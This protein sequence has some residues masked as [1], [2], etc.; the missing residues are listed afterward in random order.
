MLLYTFLNHDKYWKN[1]VFGIEIMFAF[2][3]FSFNIYC[4]PMEQWWFRCKLNFFRFLLHTWRNIS[5]RWNETFEDSFLTT[6]V[7]FFK[8]FS[9]TSFDKYFRILFR[10][11][12]WF[13][14]D[15]MIIYAILVFF[16]EYIDRR[17]F[18]AIWSRF[19]G[20]PRNPFT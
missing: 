11:C 9:L 19:L 2:F 18:D 7:E 6:L 14:K 3:I 8:E 13:I 17:L 5:L 10:V 15:N 4:C 20:Y 12:R 1:K 16:D